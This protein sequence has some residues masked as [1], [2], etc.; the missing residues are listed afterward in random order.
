MVLGNDIT[1]YYITIVGQSNCNKM[2]FMLYQVK[3][4]INELCQRAIYLTTSPCHRTGLTS[5]IKS[6]ECRSL[7]VPDYGAYQLDLRSLLA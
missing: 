5:N 1:C 4:W 3:M 7:V 6:L 2:E